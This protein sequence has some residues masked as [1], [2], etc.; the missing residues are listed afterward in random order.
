MMNIWEE[1]VKVKSLDVDSYNRFKLSAV[2]NYL[3]DAA[4][5][6]ADSLNVG[7]HQLRDKNLFWA[8]SWAKVEILDYP[9]YEDDIIIKTWHKGYHRLFALRDLLLCNNSNKVF[10]K[11]TTAW[12]VVKLDNR[13]ITP[14]ASLNI[15]DHLQNKADALTCLPDKIPAGTDMQDIYNKVIRYSDVDFNRHVNNAK[16]IN[17]ILDAYP[18]DYFEHNNIKSFEISYTS[19]ISAGDEIIIRSDYPVKENSSV[20]KV[21]AINVNNNKQVFNSIIEWRPV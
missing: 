18:H 15:P 4:A 2:F 10:C 12:L 6:A 19:E 8:L 13:R 16:Y 1:K 7:F 5:A 21:D 20:N 11:A 3:S 14:P 9:K 17:F